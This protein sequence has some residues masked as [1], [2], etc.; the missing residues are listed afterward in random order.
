[1]GEFH[2]S[3]HC[4]QLLILSTSKFNIESSD[5]AASKA[6]TQL[7]HAI[8]QSAFV[9]P[10]NVQ[11]LLVVPRLNRDDVLVHSR[12]GPHPA[13]Q[14]IEPTPSHILLET[15]TITHIGRRARNSD[16]HL[17]H[18]TYKECIPLFRGIYTLL[19]TMP[20][21][22]L[23]T[24]LTMQSQGASNPRF[25]MIVQFNSAFDGTLVNGTF[26]VLADVGTKSDNHADRSRTTPCIKPNI[27]IARVLRLRADYS[28][29]WSSS[30]FCSMAR[31]S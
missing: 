24:R 22:K 28:Y 11:V 2:A 5:N 10:F 1:M 14:I 31:R 13:S 19:R 30:S 17:P 29:H 7:Y 12:S 15:W 6:S 27:A 21:W 18:H 9:P 8:S 20:A 23:D 4:K 26:E 25:K 16:E 3:H